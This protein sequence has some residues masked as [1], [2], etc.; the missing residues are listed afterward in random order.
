MWVTGGSEWTLR[1]LGGYFQSLAAQICV[2]Q[3][4]PLRARRIPAG[5]SYKRKVRRHRG[6]MKGRMLAAAAAVHA[7]SALSL[8]YM[9][10]L[11]TR[12]PQSLIPAR[13]PA[14]A[15][16]QFPSRSRSRPVHVSMQLPGPAIPLALIAEAS[17]TS[18]AKD[19]LS[20]PTTWSLL[21]FFVVLSLGQSFG[22]RDLS[23]PPSLRPCFSHSP[24][25]PP[26]LSC[27]F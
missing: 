27:S 14:L 13:R 6:D 18:A 7:A 11:V 19:L 23:L 22:A 26:S 21:L 8:S 1:S 20:I 15:T 10:C 16:A 5:E 9:P 4:C 17:L 2:L 24:S 3:T 25:L 12:A